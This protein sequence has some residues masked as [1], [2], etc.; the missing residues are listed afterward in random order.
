MSIRYFGTTNA[1]QFQYL[2]YRPLYWLGSPGDPGLDAAHSLAQPPV[3]SKDGTTITVTLNP[4]RW[5]NG[6][7]MSAQDVMS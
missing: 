7:P 3:Y 6:E 2:M 4:Y 5:S 1:T